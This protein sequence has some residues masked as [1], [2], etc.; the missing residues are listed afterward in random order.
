MVH[1]AR[2]CGLRAVAGNGRLPFL[3]ASGGERLAAMFEADGPKPLDQI[4]WRTNPTVAEI[5]GV[6]HIDRRRTA[7]APSPISRSS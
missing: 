1:I 6:F 3:P 4:F 2:F 5:R 7:T